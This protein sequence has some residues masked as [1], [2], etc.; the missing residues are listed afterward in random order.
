MGTTL[1]GQSKA[2]T[3]DA[4]LKITDNGP[5]GAALKVVTDGLGND[6]ALQ[7]STAGVKST[8]TLEVAGATT[9]GI[10]LPIT[11]GGTGSSTA[12]GARTNLGLGTM[13][14]QNAAA[15]AITG[16][17]VTGLTSLGSDR[18]SVG[19]QG[20]TY[21]ATTDLDMTAVNTQTLD[22]TG[23]V[24]FTTSNR[25]AGRGKSVKILCDGTGR[26]LAFPAGWKFVGGTMPSSI[27]ANKT[28]ILSIL[29][30]GST[31]ASIVAA[32]AVE[33]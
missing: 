4:L 14:T 5:V 1:T 8:G 20:I 16:G 26:T 7:I 18:H 3:Y 9:L 25:G 28:G 2:S 23:N 22:L 27:A 6:S 31:D 21:A 32:W 10:D 17:D 11:E 19:V 13:A 12:A 33:P 30:Y 15:V 29:G 24:T